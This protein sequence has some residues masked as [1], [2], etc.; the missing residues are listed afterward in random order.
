MPSSSSFSSSS[1]SSSSSS[2]SSSWSPKKKYE[3]FV[4]EKSAVEEELRCQREE[5]ELAEQEH[6]TEMLRKAIK[7]REVEVR[8]ALYQKLTQELYPKGFRQEDDESAVSPDRSRMPSSS[9]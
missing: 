2:Y 5:M 1:S 8:V 7:V 3:R 4:A 6:R 9:S